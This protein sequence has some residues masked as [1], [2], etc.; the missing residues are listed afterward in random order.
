MS[1][2][3]EMAGLAVPRNDGS[4]IRLICVLFF[5]SLERKEAK[6]QGCMKMAKNGPGRG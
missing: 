6:V 4:W 5:F 3:G 2:F 1:C